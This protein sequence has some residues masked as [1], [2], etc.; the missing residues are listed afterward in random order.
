MGPRSI[1]SFVNVLLNVAYYG[2]A[3]GI[4]LTAVIILFT[5]ISI[6]FRP[7]VAI[8]GAQID[9]PASFSVDPSTL[10]VAAPSLGVDNARIQKVRGSIVFPVRTGPS[11]IGPL[12]VALGLLVFASWLVR[13]LRDFF[14]TLRDGQ[15]FVPANA[16]R[17]RRIA[18]LVIALELLRAG[19]VFMSNIVVANNFV[20][21]GLRFD[22][23]LDL[24][25]F[26]IVHGLIILVIAEVF[27]VGTRLDED[28][29][30]TV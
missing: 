18:Y 12:A 19:L 15:P 27:R 28:Q 6:P 11:T 1:A 2:L 30:L 7:Y 21:T 3:A 29:S 9:V 13:L 5:S 10:R 26:A 17:L 22:A 16:I 8:P 20:A 23:R 25:V 4:L 14:R 24:N